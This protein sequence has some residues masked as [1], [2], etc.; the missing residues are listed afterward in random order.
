MVLRAVRLFPRCDLLVFMFECKIILIKMNYKIID[1]KMTTG[2][3]FLLDIPVY[4]IKI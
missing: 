4:H 3:Y 1:I 2:N